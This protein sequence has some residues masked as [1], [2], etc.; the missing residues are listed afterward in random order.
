MF[1]REKR[2]YIWLVGSSPLEGGWADVTQLDFRTEPPT[3]SGYDLD[4]NFWRTNANISST[5]GSL[6]AYTNGMELRNYLN[7]T[8][9]TGLG[10]SEYSVHIGNEGYP[11]QQGAIFL[12]KPG[13]G[14]I[15]YLLHEDREWAPAG[16][17][18]NSWA[19]NLYY[20]EIDMS[21]NNGQGQVIEKNALLIQDTLEKGSLTA[22]R[23]ANGQDWWLL[24]PE[25]NTNRY[26]T[27][28][29]GQQGIEDIHTQALGGLVLDGGGSAVFSPDGTRYAR[30]TIVYAGGEADHCLNIY[31][32]DRCNGQ[33]SNHIEI[34]FQG[35]AAGGEGI[36][37]SEN[38]RFLYVVG[39][40]DIWQFDLLA[41]DIAASRTLVAANDGF[42]SPANTTTPFHAAQLAPNGKIYVNCSS[43]ANYFHIIHAPNQKGLA[44]NVEQHALEIPTLNYQSIPNFPY[45]GLGPLD[46][47]PCDTLGIDN[48]PPQAA[49]SYVIEDS[50]A[51]QVAFYD[52]ARF[53]PE[54]WYWAFG[55]GQ[56]ST[57]RFP[58][59]AYAEAG[60]YEV[61]LTA[62]NQAGSDTFCDTV[63]FVVSGSLPVD[64]SVAAVRVFPNPVS[65]MVTLSAQGLPAGVREVELV[66]YDALGREVLRQSVPIN[67]GGILHRLDLTSIPSGVYFWSLRAASGEG[68]GVGRV[69]KR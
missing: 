65:D 32:F 60:V 39:F 2:D 41:G 67:N 27:L 23:H 49:F 17:I 69:V 63:R 9:A 15:V 16:Y 19:Q 48:P 33:L 45:Y 24:D 64:D 8:L 18:S 58:V 36:A 40:L 68:L 42:V 55:D 4:M 46:G 38:S 34:I 50:A 35:A 5:D 56:S 7:D 14:S 20:T 44:C 3:I 22:I 28:L 10:P 51:F 54:S 59:H 11:T 47:S 43:N 30:L 21:A 66:L 61:C 37:I 52:G 1:Q 62:G 6:W 13:S 26:Y 53:S 57:E 31:D 29:F 12:P 25:A